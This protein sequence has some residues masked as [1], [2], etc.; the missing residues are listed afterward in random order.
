MIKACAYLRVSGQSQ[1]DGQDF[2]RQKQTIQAYADS[3]DFEI[4]GVYEEK[5]V[6]GK[7]ELDGWPAFKQMLADLLSN[8]CRTI[9]VERLDRLAR[10]FRVQEELLLYFRRNGVAAESAPR[11]R[12]RESEAVARSLFGVLA[13]TCQ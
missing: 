7:T 4:V 5:A 8:G 13:N 1:I 9:I 12:S 2:D 6:S 3:H 10:E 11:A